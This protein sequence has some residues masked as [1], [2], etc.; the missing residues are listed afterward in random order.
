ML[1]IAIFASFLIATIVWG[2]WRNWQKYYSTILYITICS[3]LYLVL[4]SESPLWY[5]R[6][7]PPLY[8]FKNRTLIALGQTLFVF[9]GTSLIFLGHY[10]EEKKQYIYVIAWVLLYT[11]IE[12]IALDKGII[13]HQNGWNMWWS[14]FFNLC[15][16]ILLRV[17]FLK[18]LLAWGLSIIFI[19]FIA[20]TFGLS[21]LTQN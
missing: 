16:F 9:I 18:P 1:R 13:V 15:L 3:L 4:Y 8:L 12:I 21:I 20:L 6:P 14:T 5:F 19:T 17:H 10:P 11:F 2:D 7:E